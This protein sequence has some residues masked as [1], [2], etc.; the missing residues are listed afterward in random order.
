MKITRVQL[1]ENDKLC[2]EFY[3]ADGMSGTMAPADAATGDLR[4]YKPALDKTS[5]SPH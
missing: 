3:K 1:R 4:D 5:G 2:V